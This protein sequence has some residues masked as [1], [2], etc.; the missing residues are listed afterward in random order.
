MRY[1]KTNFRKVT[2]NT[3]VRVFMFVFLGLL[4]LALLSV[5]P[6]CLPYFSPPDLSR[7]T[8][9]EIR[10]SPSTINH[11]IPG[12]ALQSILTPEEKEYTH[13]FKTFVQTD[14]DC[15]KAFAH[16][17]SK[18]KY[19]GFVW[20]SVPYANP[21]YIDC[22]HKNKRVIFFGVFENDIFTKDRRW[23]EYPRGLPNL[24]LIEPS[25]MRPF[26]L[27][28]RCAWNMQKVCLA[29]SMYRR[30]AYSYPEPNEWCDAVMQE[31]RK[32]HF[33]RAEE[34]I[35]AFKC[36][37]AGEGKCHYAMNP[38]CKPNSPPATVLLFETKAGWN[39]HGGPE[40][41][42]FD[43]HDPKGGCVLLNNGTVKFIRTTEELQQLRWK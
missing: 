28:G 16:D 6:G 18:G 4:L 15:I 25:E 26:K 37:S 17:V 34:L 29:G 8:R 31:S 30:K 11:F 2:P 36:P 40:L 14:Q 19:K 23:F 1:D 3:K 21:L 9:L 35:E 24:E 27:R 41:F 22:Y 38:N 42:T 32:I 20:G 12:T 43:N 13:S 39:Q 7:C 5:C 10:Y 33:L